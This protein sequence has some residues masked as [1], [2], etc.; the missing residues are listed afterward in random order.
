MKECAQQFQMTPVYTGKWSTA[1]DGE[2][3][4]G[5]DKMTPHTYMFRVPKEGTLKINDLVRGEVIWSLDTLGDFV[6]LRSNGQ[7]VYNF[8]VTVDDATMHI[9]H[10]I[11]AEEHLPNTLRQA[12]IYQALGFTMPSF[13]HVSLILAPDRSKLSKRHGATSVGQFR[14]MGY[15]PKSMVNYLALL[16]ESDGMGNEF[17]TMD[18]L[19]I[20]NLK[21]I[22]LCN[23]SSQ[24]KQNNSED[25][26]SCC[27]EELRLF[28]HSPG[29]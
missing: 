15:L 4:E 2:I 27:C 18:Q 20:L 23:N 3:H 8:C 17:F 5:L 24:H 16:G 14:E 26:Y 10:V 29:S 11:R 22:E 19:N 6:I 7:P 9:S 1:S 28:L 25:L 13:A 12:L 21:G